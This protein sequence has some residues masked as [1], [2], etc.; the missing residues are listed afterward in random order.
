MT[1]RDV[2]T[3]TTTK[4][5]TQEP[6]TRDEA[7]AQITE[8]CLRVA[9]STVAEV[10]GETDSEAETETARWW[11]PVLGE[12]PLVRT[13][14]LVGHAV[15][16]DNAEHMAALC[17]WWND[18]AAAPWMDAGSA[19]D[20]AYTPAALAASFRADYARAD[21]PGDVYV[22]FREQAPGARLVG[23]GA[24]YDRDGARRC[25]EL[26]YQVGARACRG[27]G[28][29]TEMVRAMCAYAFGR[30]RCASVH[31]S[32][33]VENAASTRVALRSGFRCYGL[34]PQSHVG[35]RAGRPALYDELL[36]VCFP[37]DL[38]AAIAS[39]DGCEVVL[40]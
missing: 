23:F 35:T 34:R 8:L 11:P 2:T 24:L 17:A 19:G 28:Y 27:R 32:V 31:V 29:A 33:V 13:R 22:V 18:P 1:A 4:T 25:A 6:L 14:R 39:S 15:D 16:P 9:Q 21:T 37:E 10:P 38:Q 20:T 7:L 36:L 12:T 40:C 30:A 3:T 26:S 5:E